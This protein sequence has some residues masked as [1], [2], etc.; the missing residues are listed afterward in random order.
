MTN[1]TPPINVDQANVNGP[2][3]ANQ[4]VYNTVSAEQMTPSVQG[5]MDK[6]RIREFQAATHQIDALGSISAKNTEIEMM[7]PLLRVL[8]ELS[9][10]K[11]DQCY[12]QKIYGGMKSVSNPVFLDILNA[13]AITAETLISGRE[14]ALEYFSAITN[15]GDYA[16]NAYYEHVADAVQLKDRSR[17][18]GI[19]TDE[20][21]LCS[22]I[23]G[24]LFRGDVAISVDLAESLASRFPAFNS[25]ALKLITSFQKFGED[26][27]SF[28]LWL[29]KGSEY[30]RLNA[31]ID[32][33]IEL[34]DICKGQ[35]H[36]IV[37]L[38]ANLLWL[39]FNP[40]TKLFNTCCNYANSY[41]EKHPRI[42]SALLQDK[43]L[44]NIEKNK[45]L[46]ECNQIITENKPL[47]L[48]EF[49]DLL[50]LQGKDKL[51]NWY[52]AGGSLKAQNDYEANF[53]DIYLLTILAGAKS[54]F[55]SELRSK[56]Q[57]FQSS[58]K[59]KKNELPVI[60]LHHLTESL[61]EK[62]LHDLSF[63]VLDG[64]FDITDIWISPLCINY[65]NSLLATNQNSTL[66]VL[67]K[68][69]P[70]KDMTEFLLLC[71]SNYLKGI[72]DIEGALGC[73]KQ[74]ICIDPNSLQNWDFLISLYATHKDDES[75]YKTL[76]SEIPLSIFQ[77]FSEQAVPLIYEIL[78]K[79]DPEVAESI[80]IRWFIKDPDALS[81]H[82]TNISFN[83]AKNRII[84]NQET[85]VD[86][87]LGGFRYKHG[88]KEL[89]KL[90]VVGETSHRYLIASDTSLAKQLLSM[91][92]D[93]EVTFKLNKLKLL[94]VIPTFACC[95]QIGISIRTESDDD[96]DCFIPI[97]MPTDKTMLIPAME[98][99]FRSLEN[100]ESHREKYLKTEE[101]PLFSKFL[102]SNNI[103]PME[104]AVAHLSHPQVKKSP[105]SNIGIDQ[106]EM[107]LLDVY[108]VA[109]LGLSG[110]IHGFIA[111]NKPIG[112]TI[113]TKNS[114][115]VYLEQ[116][117]NPD[118]FVAGLENGKFA[119]TT[120]VD[121]MQQ[122]KDIRIA[123][124]HVLDNAEI[125][126]LN[127]V[128][129]SQEL[130]QLSSMLDYSVFSTVK[131]A[132]TNNIPWLCIDGLYHGLFNQSGINVINNM[133]FFSRLSSQ[134]S[135]QYK[136]VGLA[137]HGTS[138]F[139]FILRYA[140]LGQ[141]AS[142]NLKEAHYILSN[143]LS[144]ILS[145]HQLVHNDA[146][147]SVLILSQLAADSLVMALGQGQFFKGLRKDYAG[148]D[149][150][151]E[152]V[153][154]TCCS[155]AI[156]IPGW[157]A[158]R[159]L[160]LFLISVNYLLVQNKQASQAFNSLANRFIEGNFL[161]YDEIMSELEKIK[162][163]ESMKLESEIP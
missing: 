153:F 81:K 111:E 15:P 129:L 44:E 154:N 100:E 56:I 152:K 127:K 110:L 35:D 67:F 91:S 114:L 92:P 46:E 59:S 41:E 45:R 63:L 133:S 126:I 121:I 21:A 37:G 107:I 2:N 155:L 7:L 132:F 108:S 137:R 103:C 161:S 26:V 144:N 27:E 105:F 140:D 73:L 33:A 58:F 88:S 40:S 122:T 39:T 98:E 118:Y 113:E 19:K 34:L 102:I 160:A 30:K 3:I 77:D 145:Q 97:E 57:A 16:L 29:L 117:Q 78:S 156:K 120:S 116:V 36:R 18:A 158:E 80:L 38:T 131:L 99:I 89:T 22:V 23:R 10:Q 112:I 142:T 17:E 104:I 32:E 90:I 42:Y 94:E 138:S 54:D 82:V 146:N 4:N 135:L 64:L 60:Q 148:N 65:L 24:L 128:D 75:E 1:S 20:P 157:T 72:N 147:Q 84:N 141:L 79:G 12:L 68:N 25:R 87:C 5:V 95:V 125:P 150:H 134:T 143:I 9:K 8:L 159:K 106:A 52:K 6:I 149:G 119:R 28:H 70:D 55:D 13:I 47:A 49:L 48:D 163:G 69:I 136:L 101:I 50:G 71:K 53:N 96:S 51:N 74:A 43:G 124:N 83:L 31:I 61:I 109:Y 76:L 151:A 130:L 93:E 85:S 86:I 139:P 162:Q 14:E 123:I 11:K 115:I 66:D 62:G